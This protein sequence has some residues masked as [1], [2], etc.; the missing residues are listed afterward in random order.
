MPYSL[1]FNAP[2][3][4]GGLCLSLLA[5]SG[6][7]ADAFRLSNGGLVADFDA[8][9]LVRIALANSSHSFS[10]AGDSAA[11]TVDGE[12]LD[13]R[14]LERVGITQRQ[15]R[16]AYTY[17]RGDKQLEVIYELK[18]GWRFVSKHLVLTLPPNGQPA[19]W[20]RSK[21]FARR[22]STPIA[23]EHK[24]SNGSGAVFLRLG[25]TDAPPEFGAF[26]ALQNPFLK[27]ERKGRPGRDGL[28]AG[29]GMAA[30]L[31]A[32]CFGPRLPGALRAHG[33]RVSGA[34]PR[35][36]EVRAASRSGP[37]TASRMLDQAEFDADDRLRGRLRPVPARRR[38]S[39]F[40]CRGART[41]IRSTSPRPRAAPNGN[42][43]STSAPPS[44]SSTRCSRRPTAPSPRSRTTPTPGAGR[45]A[46]GSASARRSARANGTSRRTRSR[47]RSRKCSTTPSAKKVKLVAYAYPTL[48]WKQNPEW[49]AWC[50]GKTGGYV[51][52]D[53]GVRSFQDWFVEQLVAFQKRTGIS[54]YSFDHW[55]I[56]YEPTKEGHKPTSKYAQWYRLPAHPRGTSPPHPGRG[57]RRP[58]AIPVVRPVDLAGR[59]LSAPDHQRRAARQLRELP[60][61]ALQPRVRRPAA[62]GHVVLPHGTIHALGNGARL[63]D[64]PDPAQRR[65]GPMCPRP[66]L[67]HA[68][69]GLISAGATRSSPRSAPP[70]STTS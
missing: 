58:P 47:R 26:L 14:D 39:A 45:T 10:L 43:S 61:P 27:W 12:T 42:A 3:V 51:G 29:P 62:L 68:R 17:A 36:V 60:R 55:W 35:R 59:I 38:A 5:S 28:R 19:A 25:E 13:V 15:D 67:P 57:H 23:R 54:G 16:I 46:S 40:T 33:R 63:H 50:G 69:L 4:I 41:T 44:A 53:T 24:A 7:G 48:G 49:T 52:V 34:Q 64:P 66:P 21:C 65:Q 56:A 37:S 9:G 11:L 8:S 22:S 70:R 20:T 31:R 2:F 18:P 6:R 30:R 1:G 32:V